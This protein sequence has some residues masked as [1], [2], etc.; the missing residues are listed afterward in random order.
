MAFCGNSDGMKTAGCIIFR[1]TP[2][3]KVSAKNI[4]GLGVVPKQSNLKAISHAFRR[5][6]D[7]YTE[8]HGMPQGDMG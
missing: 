6:R 5:P 4:T 1:D 3:R 8:W 7:P 2:Y